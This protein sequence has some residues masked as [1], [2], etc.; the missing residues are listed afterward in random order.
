M[1]VCSMLTLLNL[2]FRPQ[3]KMEKKNK[4]A[5][6]RQGHA[7]NQYLEVHMHQLARGFRHDHDHDDLK[8]IHRSRKIFMKSVGNSPWITNALRMFKPKPT[9]ATMRTSRG[10]STVC[11]CT[12][13]SI[14]CRQ[15]D[16][17][18]ASRKTPLKKAPM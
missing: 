16:N 12:K 2:V 5:N 9:H 3:R 17:A 4:G 15:I 7:E 8:I 18:N 1:I 13:R 10:E 11:I 14:D 6:L